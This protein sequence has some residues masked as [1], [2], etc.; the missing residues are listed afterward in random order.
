MEPP[1]LAHF[2]CWLNNSLPSHSGRAR[3]RLLPFFGRRVYPKPVV[4]WAVAKE[5]GS[6]ADDGDESKQQPKRHVLRRVGDSRRRET[7]GKPE[8]TIK[9]PD[10]L[11]H[12]FSFRF[13]DKTTW[14]D[15]DI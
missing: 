14:P 10:V 15:Y 7:D 11:L 13:G 4:D 3:E 8:K 1:P 12:K 2:V 6:E 5:S 9:T